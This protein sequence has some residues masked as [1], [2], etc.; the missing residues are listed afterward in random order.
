M[1]V[2]MCCLLVVVVNVYDIV[3]MIKLL[4]FQSSLFLIVCE[5]PLLAL[6]D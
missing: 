5:C 3:C 1:V 2:F 4:T 6:A